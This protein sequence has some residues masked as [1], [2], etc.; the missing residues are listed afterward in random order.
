M[1]RLLGAFSQNGAT[2]FLSSF[3]LLF[4][5]FPLT[6][7][8]KKGT[9]NKDGP[10]SSFNSIARATFHCESGALPDPIEMSF[11]GAF[12]LGRRM[13]A[14]TRPFGDI[15]IFVSPTPFFGCSVF[16]LFRGHLRT[17]RSSGCPRSFRAMATPGAGF[18]RSRPWALNAGPLSLGAW[19]W[20]EL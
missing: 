18:G 7:E 20:F 13:F 2:A 3:L 15:L 12:S 5:W 16:F 1:S 10:E 8:P 14:K 19:E 17:G 11:R 4:C 9:H 6:T